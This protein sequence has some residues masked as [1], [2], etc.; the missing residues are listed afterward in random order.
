MI[1]DECETV[2]HCTKHGCIPKHQAL[3]K[4]AENARELG[5]D[6][7]QYKGAIEVSV[8]FHEGQ[9]MFAVPKQ[10]APVQQEPIGSVHVD[11][12]AMLPSLRPFDIGAKI[13]PAS[14][15][16]YDTS[17]RLVYTSPPAQ[18]TWVGLT[19]E[20]IARVVSL[21]GFAPDWVEAHIAIQIV[22]VLEAKLKEKNT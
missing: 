19:D 9:R 14:K 16:K 12:L 15:A 10:P 17:Y 18:R 4:M 11:T 5:L 20:E 8:I 3:D 1:C 22:R 6:Y 2:A 13:H 7:E 21:A